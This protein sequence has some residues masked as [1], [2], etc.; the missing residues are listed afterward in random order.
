MFS[1]YLKG[2]RVF[3]ALFLLFGFAQVSSAFAFFPIKE[4]KIVVF[5]Q[6]VSVPNQ[7]EVL[8]KHKVIVYKRL[9][10]INAQAVR[11][12]HQE[13]S[14]LSHDQRVLR[15]DPDVEVYALP[16]RSLCDRYPWWPWC[17][18]RPRRRPRPSASRGPSSPGAF[19]GRSARL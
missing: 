6:N 17:H 11:L 1:R 7:N 19:R 15:V 5:R 9:R 16:R 13:V 18:K 2:V 14:R 4:R 10:L 3:L 8:K 12:S